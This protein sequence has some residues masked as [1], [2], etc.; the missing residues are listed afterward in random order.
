MVTEEQIREAAYY[1]WEQEGHPEGKDIEHYFRAKEI[2][3]SGQNI[4]LNPYGYTG[5]QVPSDE[6]HACQVLPPRK[7]ENPIVVKT[8]KSALRPRRK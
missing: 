2:L 7:V 1:L 6:A 8:S 5:G 3:E 4:T